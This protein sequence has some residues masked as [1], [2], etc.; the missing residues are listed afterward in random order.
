ME[1]ISERYPRQKCLQ[2]LKALSDQ[3]LLDTL[4]VADGFCYHVLA[5]LKNGAELSDHGLFEL[6]GLVLEQCGLAEVKHLFT[7]KLE[8]I[9]HILTSG[10]ASLCCVANV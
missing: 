9:Q 3:S 5:Q 10:L 6:L 1:Y 7:Q 2:C 8:D 4:R